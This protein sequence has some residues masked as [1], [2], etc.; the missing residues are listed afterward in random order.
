MNL[1]SVFTPF[2]AIL[3]TIA[4]G[5]G[6][7]PLADRIPSDAIVYAGWA[8]TEEMGPG[9]DGSHLKAMIDASEIQ[10][11]IDEVIPTIIERIAEKEPGAKEPATVARDA[12]APIWRHPTAVY[13]GPVDMT[14][15]GEPQPSIAII[16]NAGKDATALE[17]SW[18]TLVEKSQAPVPMVV[19]NT[20]GVVSLN[21]GKV[22]QDVEGGAGSLAKSRN[23]AAA[24]TEQKSP[25]LAVYLDIE[26]AVKLIDSA[27]VKG[28]DAK[29]KEKWPATRDALGLN[30][31]K[32][33]SFAQGFDGKDWATHAF[34]EAP[35]PRKGVASWLEAQP[36]SDAAL[37]AIPVTATIAGVG[38]LD[39]AKLFDGIRDAAKQLDEN[40]AREFGDGIAQLNEMLKLDLRKDV[41]GSL[42]DEWSYY[43]A[44]EVTGRGPLGV[45]IVNRLKDANKAQ[46]VSDKLK[47]VA[48][49]VIAGQA[50]KDMHIEF[51]QG[52]ING[53]TVHYLA[54]P[55]FTPSWAI[56]NGNMYIGLYPQVV[57]D[58]A[59]HVS[60]EGKSI[61]DNPSFVALRKRLGDQKAVSLQFYDLPRSAPTSYQ[62]WLL[63][64]SFAKFGDVF[65]VDTP[66]SMFPPLATLIQ[67]VSPAGSVS[68]VDERG[69]HLRAVTPFPGSTVLASDA[70]GFMDVQT[71]AL[72]VSI[73]LPSLS[74]AREQAN[75]VKSASNL[76]QIGLAA[77][78]YA[79]E[80][81]GKFPD[82]ISE[83]LGDITPVVFVNP[84]TKN[85][86]PIAA[87]DDELKRWV[88]QSSDY[89]YVGKGKTYRAPATEILAYEKPQGL[90]D[91]INIL[92]CDGH[93]EFVLMEQ[94]KE[95][96]RRGR[97]GN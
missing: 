74:R 73:M 50:E 41:L 67:H 34:I 59:G 84:R 90:T 56:Q 49:T 11:V 95:A 69:W 10:R 94:A 63:V 92:F 18:K 42:G 87:S 96:I 33:I 93:V 71:N 77:Q 2:L 61:L 22:P 3:L 25:V 47:E 79:N 58:A 45:V 15:P 54:I 20:N 5:L 75:R 40:G 86:V 14:G 91:G 82:Q 53:V 46:S 43:I 32:R 48:N 29:A 60:K 36:V 76:R 24:M 66:I 28:N 57:A 89:T 52:Q 9:Y 72:L 27:V 4:G 39:L 80:H 70:A 62:A 1:S 21:I 37:K 85:S 23:F 55:F 7:Q 31:I 13:I 19:R 12:L 97:L 35:A 68:W 16:C 78:I 81:K 8:G 6:A 51:K 83:T 64:S 38:R 17:K 26:A 44:P 30:G 88:N 65:G